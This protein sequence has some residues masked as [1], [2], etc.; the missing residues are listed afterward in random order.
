MAIKCPKCAVSAGIGIDGKL[1]FLGGQCI[2]LLGTPFVHE[3]E[4]CPILAAAMGTEVKLPIHSE[5]IVRVIFRPVLED[6]VWEI[7]ALCPN[8]VVERI[9]WFKSEAEA[10][11]WIA[12]EESRS[13]LLAKGYLQASP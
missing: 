4:R 6:G 1:S 10:M 2:E 5:K 12:N 13:W 7:E 3:F 11:R 8:S 9:K